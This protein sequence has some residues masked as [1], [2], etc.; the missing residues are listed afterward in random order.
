M[1]TIDREGAFRVK[2]VDHALKEVPSGALAVNLMLEVLEQY[3]P[4]TEQWI[5][6]TESAPG[7]HVYGDYWVVGKDGSLK[8]AICQDLI[9]NAGWDGKLESVQDKDFDAWTP[10][11]TKVEKDGEYYRASFCNAYD[12]TPGGGGMKTLDDDRARAYAQKHG[13]ALKALFA[14]AKRNKSKPATDKPKPP[15]PPAPTAEAEGDGIPF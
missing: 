9:R 13:A 10:F 12:S 8:K 7:Y 4:S 14:D 6:W 1:P 15:P 3:D 2:V 11:Q 5:D